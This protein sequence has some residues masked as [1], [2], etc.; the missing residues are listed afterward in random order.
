MPCF[1]NCGDTEA[2]LWHDRKWPVWNRPNCNAIYE[3]S[4]VS[5]RLQ[6]QY[7][8]IKANETGKTLRT[9]L[10]I[11]VH[12]K[13]EYNYHS[14]KFNFDNCHKQRVFSFLKVGWV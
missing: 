7:V 2:R 11:F 14:F 12:S 3:I 1:S 9:H 10:K 5:V 6:S 8:I 4:F 13:S